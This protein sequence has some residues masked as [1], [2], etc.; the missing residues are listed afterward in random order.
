MRDRDE[1]GQRD[2][3]TEGERNSI[4]S[5]ILV[6]PDRKKILDVNR[7]INIQNT[8]CDIPDQP[9]LFQDVQT[10]SPTKLRGGFILQRIFDILTKKLPST[11]VTLKASENS[12]QSK[13]IWSVMIYLTRSV[14]WG[15]TFL[16]CALLWSD[17]CCGAGVTGDH[18]YVNTP[19]GKVIGSLT[20][21]NGVEYVAY[22]SIP[23][24]KPPI[25][26]L[27][28]KR[29]QPLDNPTPAGEPINS[30]DYQKSC[31]SA[32]KTSP[33]KYYGEDCLYLN[34][35]VPAGNSGPLAVMVWLHGGGLVAGSTFPEPWKM[36]TQ[37]QVI[38]VTVN[39]RL[40]ALGFMTTLDQAFPTNNGLW[41]QYMAVRWVHENIQSFNGDANSITLFGES[42]G[43]TSTG[44]HVISP[45]SSGHFHKAVLQS[46]A[47]TSS[48]ARDS[49][50]TTARFAKLVGC[51]TPS[52]D[53]DKSCLHDVTIEDI[54]KYSKPEWHVSNRAQR[55][56][57]F[58]W[59]AVIDGEIIPD[60]PMRLLNNVTFLEQQGVFKKDYMI[61]VLNDEG[62]ILTTNF[63][64]PV[65]VTAL[66]DAQFLKDL[67]QFLL[68]IRYGRKELITEAVIDS[69]NTFFTGHA[70]LTSPPKTTSVLDVCGDLHVVVPALEA[71]LAVTQQG[72]S[73]I[74]KT[75][76]YHFDFCPAKPALAAPC[77]VHGAEVALQFP[78]EKITDPVLAG[79]SDLFIALLTRFARSSDPGTVIA[80]GWPEYEPRSGKYLR[81][82]PTPDVR[83]HLYQY[84][85]QFWLET[86]PC[87]MY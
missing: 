72:A 26:K 83:S 13:M 29:P 58:V 20:Q 65:P 44:L 4:K 25:G 62:G 59:R 8:C 21:T 80:S 51:T 31:W 74:A 16:L 11:Q 76:L 14:I 35:Y 36:V 87:V 47:M 34:V 12:D 19:V 3:K 15:K 69:V 66:Q 56:I 48:F 5:L 23:F 49:M 61:G 2:G 77:F 30:L 33:S 78:K 7:Q 84:R 18:Y 81:I 60:E 70:N 86:L 85:M 54:L 52:G 50:S 24:A 43:A 71:A 28:F 53:V 27:R 32:T 39:Y 79:L 41:D 68:Y 6:T 40:G 55:Q 17:D 10:F 46:G 57:D 45:V 22:K 9:H 73:K 38:V 63:F 64:N 75:F 82:S 37:G 1:G 42:A 67:E